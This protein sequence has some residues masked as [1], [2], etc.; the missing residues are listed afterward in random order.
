MAKL[1]DRLPNNAPG[2]YYVDESCAQC[3][4]CWDAAPE[5]F[6]QDEPTGLSYVCRQ[7]DSPEED[8]AAQEALDGCPCESIGDDGERDAVGAGP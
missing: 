6:K 1:Q 8:D 5:I 7:P 4:V 3:G 2:R